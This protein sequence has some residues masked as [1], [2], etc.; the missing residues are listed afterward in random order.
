M[1]ETLNLLNDVHKNI[2]LKIAES[3]ELFNQISEKYQDRNGRKTGGIK[4]DPWKSH[5]FKIG[6][7][8]ELFNGIHEKYHI[9][10][11]K[12]LNAWSYSAGPWVIHIFEMIS[13]Y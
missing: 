3:L 12:W 10:Y 7:F 13:I 9:G 1:A 4:S 8:L 6:V 2:T 5:I 11:S